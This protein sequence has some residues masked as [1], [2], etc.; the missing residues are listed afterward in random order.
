MLKSLFF[1]PVLLDKRVAFML[2]SIDKGRLMLS[3]QACNW[4]P[5][6]SSGLSKVHT[7]RSQTVPSMI[8]THLTMCVCVCVHAQ[9][10]DQDR[11]LANVKLRVAARVCVFAC[12]C[13]FSLRFSSLSHTWVSMKECVWVMRGAASGERSSWPLVPGL[14]W[15]MSE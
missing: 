3:V 9:S 7:R 4:H 1:P 8:F 14:S 11:G 13:Q 15:Q 12:A 2:R 5:V 6:G 10:R